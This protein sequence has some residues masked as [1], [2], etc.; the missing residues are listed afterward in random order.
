LVQAEAPGDTALTDRDLLAS[1]AGADSLWASYK[2][3]PREDAVDSDTPGRAEA[4]RSD[5]DLREKYQRERERRLRPDGA[6]QYL[7]IAGRLAHYLDAPYDTPPPDRAPRSGE[8]EVLIVGAGFGGMLAAVRLQAAGVHDALLIEKAGDFGGT[9]FWNRYP[10]V[11]CDTESYIYM[12]LLEEM[13]YV[14]T[15]KY[16]PG[17]EIL[18]HSR[19]VGERYG[20]YDKTLFRTEVTEMRWLDQ[21]ARWRVTTDRGDVFSA[22]FVVQ[23]VGR[24]HLPQLPGIPGIET[25]KG[26][27]FH[28]SRWDYGYTGGDHTGN[29]TGLAD[30]R[31]GIIGAGATAV[32]CV[33]HLSAWSKQLYV[34]QRTPA[35]VDWR[36][37]RPTDPDW[38]K[39]LRPG[40]QRARV[41]NFDAVIS[42][43][44]VEVDLVNDGWTDLIPNVRLAA[45]KKIQAG[46]QVD[47]PG[48]VVQAA[49]DQRMERIRARI[50]AVIKDPATA[51]ALKPWYNQACKRPLFHDRYLDS[52]NR[53]N[54]TLVDTEGRGVER[55]TE[56]SVVTGGR[57][58]ELDCLIY[59][60]GFEYNSDY[61]Q[62]AGLD[63][64]G[65]GGLALSEKWRNGVE[66][67][68]GLTS[69]GFP[70]CFFL[71][72][73]QSGHSAN[74][75]HMLDV[76]TRH[77]A[78]LVGEVT[79][80][81]ARTV[82]PTAEAE[83]AWTTFIVDHMAAREPALRDCTPGYINN[84]GRF[85][86]R[87]RKNSQFANP[88]AFVRLLE[89]W[90][91]RGDLAG[92]ELTA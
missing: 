36:N 9:W 66:S 55:I 4:G 21:A 29:L 20:L 8:V 19:R 53:A 72:F 77:L 52:F 38:A 56:R 47:D 49:E 73:T 2:N 26:K 37:D 42:G 54:V 84:E 67:L 33:P 6:D 15:R 90:R 87:S 18:D 65:R 58:Y 44:E 27:S 24:L 88:V 79:R 16:A 74:A 89:D 64:H 32:Q 41:E 35:A 61:T 59:A 63:A 7:H 40:W 62:R 39:D 75:Q 23:A 11:A 12:P 92:L 68:H 91:T 17:P 81:G 78:Y 5:Q 80:R 51:E 13:G 82:E 83:A 1:A 86:L 22:R 45:F 31:V 85:D 25:F 70:N 69:R 48:A 76:N 46:E 10:G 50:D 57:E 43:L 60:T 34:F 14:P 71:M 3:K 30:K 28:T